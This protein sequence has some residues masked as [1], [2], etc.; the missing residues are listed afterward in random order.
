MALGLTTERLILSG[1]ARQALLR[2]RTCREAASA[3]VAHRCGATRTVSSRLAAVAIWLSVDIGDVAICARSTVGRKL[4]CRTQRTEPTRA[5]G[6]ASRRPRRILVTATLTKLASAHIALH[7]VRPCST[8]RRLRRTKPAETSQGTI[9]AFS[10]AAQ[11]SRGRMCSLWTR[12]WRTRTLHAERAGDT[13]QA[14]G[15]IPRWL[16]CASRTRLARVHPAR[17]S[18]APRAA[19]HWWPP[20]ACAKEA[21]RTVEALRFAVNL[22]LICIRPSSTEWLQLQTRTFRT[23]VPR[24]AWLA[25]GRIRIGLI[26]ARWAQ[27]TLHRQEIRSVAAWSAHGWSY[28]ASPACTTR[29]AWC[30][31]LGTAEVGRIRVCASETWKRCCCSLCT[32]VTSETRVARR[33][34]SKLLVSPNLALDA[35][36]L[37]WLTVVRPGCTQRLVR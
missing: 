13:R 28:N 29:R 23:K 2:I 34:T 26:L 30:T 6:D 8:C 24:V 1:G 25:I 12:Q 32:E 15:R 4:H 7:R 17:V 21:R 10:L 16:S 14:Q 22:C 9:D 5:A 33:L 18:K 3:A 37:R 36:L 11:A 20:A 27:L 19:A 35:R 31:H